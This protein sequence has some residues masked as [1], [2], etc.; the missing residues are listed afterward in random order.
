LT[1]VF[2][3]LGDLLGLI[4]ALLCLGL[5]LIFLARGRKRP[6]Q[7]VREI[8]AF[9]RFRREVG[10]AVE[11]GKRLHISLGRGSLN[12]LPAG[13]ALVGLTMLERCARA[14]SISD[15]PPVATSGDSVVAILSRDTLRAT[16]YNIGA[17]R[18]YE[19][20]SGRLS[21]LTPLSYAAGAMSV[22]HDEN[23]S[24]NVLAGHFGGEVGL[25]TEAGERAGSL[26]IASSDSLPAQ[27]VLFASTD[28]PLVGEEL[29]AGG[30]YLGAGPL[31][32]ASLRTQDI[33]RWLLVAIMIG[34]ALL[35]VL[36]VL[37]R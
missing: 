31:H 7:D 35:R 28:E 12:N 21:G 34:G 11:S 19:P 9:N 36:G 6:I 5:M 13:S 29:Y 8:P 25:L 15:R 10:L 24:A 30:A 37:P 23:V 2:E 17:D 3:F 27:A 33:L 22:I 1:L 20:T 32:V 18:R 14:A 26:T 4:F 16:Y